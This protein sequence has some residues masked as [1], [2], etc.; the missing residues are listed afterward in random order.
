MTIREAR[1]SALRVF[2]EAEQSRRRELEAER[3]ELSGVTPLTL[4]DHLAILQSKQQFGRLRSLPEFLDILADRMVSVYGESP[5]V[6]FVLSCRERARLLREA[7]T[8]QR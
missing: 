5:N 4:A 8:D 6:D 3:R 1:K 2:E 7:V